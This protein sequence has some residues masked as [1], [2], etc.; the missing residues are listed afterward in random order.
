VQTRPAAADRSDQQTARKNNKVIY[1]HLH[2]YL[3]QA[4]FGGYMPSFWYLS[5]IFF[6]EQTAVGHIVLR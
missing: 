4:G 2:I 6:I 1:W 3:L 5:G